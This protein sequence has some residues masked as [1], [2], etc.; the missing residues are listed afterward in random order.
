[1]LGISSEA[2][3]IAGVLML[4]LLLGV[5]GMAIFAPDSAPMK[6][7]QGIFKALWYDMMYF[8]FGPRMVEV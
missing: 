1:M 3:W 2:M 8:M 7:G 5:V 6:F 4:I